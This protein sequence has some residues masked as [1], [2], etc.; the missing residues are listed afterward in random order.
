MKLSIILKEI[1]K[2]ALFFA[3]VL[4]CSSLSS[5]IIINSKYKP[6]TYEELMR[7]IERQND[8]YREA[9]RDFHY[10]MEMAIRETQ[11]ERY[12]TAEYYLRRAQNINITY[13]GIFYPIDELTKMIQSVQQIREYINR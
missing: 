3:F 8:A 12:A 13:N 10:N 1:L 5:Q 7:P 2:V 4:K 9:E 11:R 6:Y